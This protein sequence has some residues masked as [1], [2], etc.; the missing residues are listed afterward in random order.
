MGTYF[1]N[2]CPQ[3]LC[4]NSTRHQLCQTSVDLQR[5][6]KYTVQKA[7]VREGGLVSLSYI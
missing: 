4:F 2:M 5:T 3:F 6:S 7:H 1:T